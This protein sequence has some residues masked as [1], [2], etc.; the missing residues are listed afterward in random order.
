MKMCCISAA[1]AWDGDAVRAYRTCCS[2]PNGDVTF[3][4]KAYW[5]GGSTDEEVTQTCQDSDEFMTGC[6]GL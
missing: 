2:T 4:C 5:S 1:D 6:S 3:S